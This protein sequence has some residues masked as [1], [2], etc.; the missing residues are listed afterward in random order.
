MAKNTKENNFFAF[1][2]KKASPLRPNL[3]A[4]VGEATRGERVIKC[5]SL[6]HVSRRY[7]YAST[8]LA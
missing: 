6:E 3:S 2:G 7:S 1:G 5:F 8:T 4:N